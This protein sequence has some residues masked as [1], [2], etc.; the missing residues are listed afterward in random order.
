MRI[1]GWL[2]RRN[3]WLDTNGIIILIDWLAPRYQEDGEAEEEEE[4]GIFFP[5][6]MGWVETMVL[7]EFGGFGMRFGV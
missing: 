1:A 7:R 4:V 3:G 6:R 2:Q 5:P